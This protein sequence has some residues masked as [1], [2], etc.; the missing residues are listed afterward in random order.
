MTPSLTTCHL[1]KLLQNC[2]FYYDS[3]VLD[4]CDQLIVTIEKREKNHFIIKFLRKVTIF[5]LI[6]QYKHDM[7]FSFFCYLMFS[8][9]N[10]CHSG[11]AR[12]KLIKKWVN[13]VFFVFPTT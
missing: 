8:L 3:V 5:S 9:I 6:H 13:F 4:M 12:C 10:L 1:D 2:E 11:L 7:I